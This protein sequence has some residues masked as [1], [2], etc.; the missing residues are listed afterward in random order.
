MMAYGNKYSG[1][2]LVKRYVMLMKSPN[3]AGDRVPT[4]HLLSPKGANNQ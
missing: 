1:K 3:N 4:G 2:F